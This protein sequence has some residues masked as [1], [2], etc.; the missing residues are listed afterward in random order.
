MRSEQRR[1]GGVLVSRTGFVLLL[2][3]V[4]GLLLPRSAR[5]QKPPPPVRPRSTIEWAKRER[6]TGAMRAALDDYRTACTRTR[7]AECVEG[8]A[9]TSQ[10]LKANADALKAYEEL[11]KTPDASAALKKE[12][13][14]R[15]AE[16]ELYVGAIRVIVEERDTAVTLDGAKIGVAPLDVTLRVDAGPHTVRTNRAT[17][18]LDIGARSVIPLEIKD[19]SRPSSPPT[20]VPISDGKTSPNAAQVDAKAGRPA[21]PAE[22]DLPRKQYKATRVVDPPKIDGRLDDAIWQTTPRE[23]RFYSIVSKPYGVPAKNPT[24][25]QVAY[26][27]RYVYIAF[28]ARYAGPGVRD[29]SLPLDEDTASSSELVSVQIDA[30][31]DHSSARIFAVTRTGARIDVDRVYNGNND[32]PAWRGVWDV[33]AVRS[34]DLWT[35][36]MRI[37]WGTLGA[38]SNEASFDVGINF[39]RIV[40]GDEEESSVWELPPAGLADVLPP[41]FFGH[42]VGLSNIKPHQRL[43]LQPYLAAAFRSEGEPPLS[44]LRDF[45]GT[46]G[47]GSIY[48]GIY[49]RYRPP[50]PVKV[51][52]TINPDFSQVQP[53]Q[54]LT[55]SDRFELFRPELRPFFAE[56][57]GTFEFGPQEAQVFYTRRIGLQLDANGVSRE[58]PII[59]GGKAI[60]QAGST[61]VAVLNV[62]TSS[63]ARTLSFDDNV[64]VVKI[65]QL[66]EDGNRLG[67]ILMRRRGPDGKEHLV[68][69]AEGKLT[70]FD[71]H[72]SI[73]AFAAR[74]STEASVGPSAHCGEELPGAR[75]SGGLEGVNVAWQ[76]NEFNAQAGV[77]EVSAGYDPQLGYIPVADEGLG[78]RIS[79]FASTYQPLVRSDYLSRVRLSML[80]TRAT[81]P[82]DDLIYERASIGLGGLMLNEAMFNV[83]VLGAHEVIDQ[84][85]SLVDSKIPIAQGRFSTLSFFA[86]AGTPPRRPVQVILHYREGQVFDAY[87]R[88]PY[89]TVAVNLGRF[90]S[91]VQYAFYAVKSAT[92]VRASAHELSFSAQIAYAPLARSVLVIEANTYNPYAAAQLTNSYQFG[93]LSAISI[94]LSQRAP[95]VESWFDSPD[96]RVLL[97]FVYGLSPF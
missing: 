93:Q 24:E 37:P 79:T 23:S 8:I 42:L 7:N 71:Q 41:S 67:N 32:N 87:Q 16:L 20:A 36:E 17:R 9:F 76:S 58:V 15:I 13:R 56:D 61:E 95:R 89:A 54:A 47:H 45:S 86:V 55:N 83:S 12:A 91:S 66:F 11:V 65:N 73:Y 69:G 34:A 25:V 57:R 44:S 26:D 22:E 40:P 49:A 94:V 1:F 39:Q 70:L 51:D 19:E 4:W 85:F 48:A 74:S 80:L 3:M 75:C 18:T 96:R 38:R 31:H 10:R 6:T 33:E 78:A 35:A 2:L 53:D 27:E 81:K 21:A 88:N 63:P 52:F 90:A 77:T 46:N 72:A 64:T 62:E 28:R 84:A 50:L 59:Y 14:A 43:F 5:A 92:G 60:V 97:S 29:D 68:G 30:R 82:E